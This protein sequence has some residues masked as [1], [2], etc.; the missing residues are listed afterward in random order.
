[1]NVNFARSTVWVGLL[2]LAAV[3]GAMAQEPTQ[4]KFCG[5]IHDFTPASVSPA[6]PWE[7]H[8]DWT[9]ILEDNATKAVFSGAFTMQRSD[10]WDISFGDPDDPSLRTPHTHHITMVNGVVTTTDTGFTVNGTAKVEASGNPAPFGEE[11]PL[12]IDVTGGTVIKY[13]NVALT[14]SD[15][16]DTHF[17]S[18]PL[19]GVIRN[20]K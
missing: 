8:G 17:G 9:L 1:M 13:S 7:I 15:P 4:T 5:S 14:F 11:S 18:E 10:E 12:E 19:D 3:V 6:G 2:L 20:C 16:A